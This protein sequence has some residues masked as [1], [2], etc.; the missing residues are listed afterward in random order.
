VKIVTLQE[1][2]KLPPGTIYSN[3]EPA[4]CT[5]LFRKG[6]TCA[7]DNGECFDFFYASVCAECY[8]ENDLTPMVDDV[9]TRWAL[10]DEGAQ[11]AVYE[12][13]DLAVMRKMLFG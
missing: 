4:I 13:A 6:D 2:F 1:F 10:Y 5:G 7:L 12:P 8:S 3:Y 11:F 9:E